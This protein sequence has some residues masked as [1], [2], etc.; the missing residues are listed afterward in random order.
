MKKLITISTLATLILAFSISAF[1][2]DM[3]HE[4]NGD[5]KA[6]KGMKMGGD[7]SGTM[8]DGIAAMEKG[9]EAMKNGSA[10]MKDPSTRMKGMEIMKKEMMPMHNGMKTVEE[11]SMKTGNAAE[12]KEAMKEANTG[13]MAMMRG[14]GMAKDGNENGFKMM[15]SGIE[16]MEK[17]VNQLKSV[18]K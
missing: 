15:N 16:K 17:A 9:V 14:M 6:M 7:H 4:G 13:M 8:A 2:M 11:A 18:S 5:M 12:Y 10:L 3:N 1:A